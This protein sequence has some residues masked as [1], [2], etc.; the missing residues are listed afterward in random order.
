MLN[1]VCGAF[2]EHLKAQEC[3]HDGRGHAEKVHEEPELFY[4]NF[5]FYLL[6]ALVVEALELRCSLILFLC[7]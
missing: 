5:E 6:N 4:A 3:H 7:I 1:K 2:L